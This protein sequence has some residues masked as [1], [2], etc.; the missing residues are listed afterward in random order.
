MGTEYKIKVATT[1]INTA[2]VNLRLRRIPYFTSFDAE[3]NYYIYRAESNTGEMP[4]VAL[5]L[6]SDGFYYVTSAHPT[7]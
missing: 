6:E 1:P 4:D 5:K 7:R 2:Q 3:R